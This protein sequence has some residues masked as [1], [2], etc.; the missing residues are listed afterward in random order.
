MTAASTGSAVH[1]TCVAL[2]NKAITQAIADTASPLHGLAAGDI[3]VRDG[4]LV[5]RTDS[6]KSDTFAELV[7]RNGSPLEIRM[8]A[9][10]GDNWRTYAMHSFGAIF[11]EALVDPDLGEIRVSRLTGVYGVGTVLNQK[12]ARSQ[13]IGGI[14]FG[15][16]MALT[17]QMLLDPRT[18]RAINADL[19]EYHVPVH[20]D[21][22]MIDVAFIDA[23]DTALGALGAKGVGEIGITG[24]AAAISN[25]VYHATG[26]RVRDL[27]IT[28]D[29]VI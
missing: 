17:E 13:I 25:A 1:E 21:I 6:A 20:A 27:P 14:V 5:A 7:R 4:K 22:P 8:D 12:T 11:A 28:L 9:Q 18:G 3:E 29:R 16:G 19:A 24:V 26:V 15:V 23:P 10:P 2:R